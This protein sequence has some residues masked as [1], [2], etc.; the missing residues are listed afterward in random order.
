MR[1][2][3]ERVQ[4][5]LGE[6]VGAAQEGLLALSVGVG[7]GVLAELMEEEVVQVVGPRSKPD[8]ARLAYRHGHERGE[9]TLGGRVD[10]F[11]RSAYGLV[12]A[13]LENEQSAEDSVAEGF[14]DFWRTVSSAA[15][16]DDAYRLLLTLVHRAAVRRAWRYPNPSQSE[17]WPLS[18]LALRMK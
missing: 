13:M 12:L 17:L 6:L 1:E 3:P 16:P 8:S 18:S 5:A 4:A 15:A 11:G 9:V 7:L 14:A 2:L 10:R